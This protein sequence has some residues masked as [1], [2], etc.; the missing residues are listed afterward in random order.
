MS[1]PTSCAGLT[2]I[3]D[4]VQAEEYEFSEHAERERQA[5][6]MPILDVERAL[7]S[8]EI[9]EDYPNDPRGPSCLI[10]G[11]GATGYPIHL[12]CGRSPKGTLRLITVYVPSLPRWLDARTRAR[13]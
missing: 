9:L 3:R 1:Q 11:Y 8:A 12:V 10:V 7:L 6:R 4:Q 13:R 5:D 2:W